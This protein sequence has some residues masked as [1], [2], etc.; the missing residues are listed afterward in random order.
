VEE[1][2]VNMDDIQNFQQNRSIFP[3]QKGKGSKCT[4]SFY[5]KTSMKYQ[6]VVYATY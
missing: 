2:G 4:C 5:E 3:L 6:E 1:S